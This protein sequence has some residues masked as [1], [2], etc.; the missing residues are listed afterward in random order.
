MFKNPFSFDGR[1][2]RTEYGL[3]F[4]IFA[5]AKVITQFIAVGIAGTNSSDM[6]GAIVLSY[7][8]LIPLLW[9]FLAQGAKRCHDVG[10]NGWWQII[11]FYPIYL[12]FGE[13]DKGDNEYGE[14]P[15]KTNSETSNF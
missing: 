7:I 11:P 9:F 4:I 13:G 6:S 10:K 12:I 8:F 2:R 1:I 14:D 5:I 3:S 15:K